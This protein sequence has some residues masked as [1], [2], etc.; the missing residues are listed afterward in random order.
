MSNNTVPYLRQEYE[1][2]KAS[3]ESQPAILQRFLES[4][5]GFIA[6]ALIEK[7]RQVRFSLP[8]RVVVSQGSK[9][10]TFPIPEAKRQITVGTFLQHDV[11]EEIGRASCRE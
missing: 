10:E 11:R 8:D 5:A 7:T 2:Q 3:F 6:H 9:V 1:N 4:Q